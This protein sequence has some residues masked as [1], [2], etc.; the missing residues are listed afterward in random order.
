[1]RARPRVPG[2]PAGTRP[3]RQH[4]CLPHLTWS[5][6][7]LL[8]ENPSL[9]SARQRHRHRTWIFSTLPATSSASAVSFDWYTAAEQRPWF[10]A[11]GRGAPCG[12]PPATAADRPGRAP[13][14][15]APTRT[16]NPNPGSTSARVYWPDTVGPLRAIFIG[17]LRGSGSGPSQRVDVM[18]PGGPGSRGAV[19]F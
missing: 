2:S 6:P 19:T 11:S 17:W 8:P 16:R 13:T 7:L 9:L 5:H 4:Q 14:R 10:S 12:C 1:G 3:A 15:G 18:E